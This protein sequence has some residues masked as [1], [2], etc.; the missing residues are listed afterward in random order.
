MRSALAAMTMMMFAGCATTR[1]DF[2]NVMTDFGHTYGI[3]PHEVPF[4]HL[5]SGADV[6]I[7]ES[8]D[9]HVDSR[10]LFTQVRERL[11]PSWQQIVRTRSTHDATVIFA[12]VRRETWA[13]MIVTVDE[14]QVTLVHADLD[15][16]QVQKWLQSKS[17]EWL[18]T[19]SGDARVDGVHSAALVKR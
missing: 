14:K 12:S 11:G 1:A 7:A 13:L 18:G 15:S 6:A 2:D 8:T 3:R 9:E 19:P 10:R 4:A 17:T 5:L 16:A